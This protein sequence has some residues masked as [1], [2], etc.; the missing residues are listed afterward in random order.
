MRKIFFFLLLLFLFFGTI[1][2]VGA[3]KYSKAVESCELKY[4][5]TNVDS[6]CARGNKVVS[7]TAPAGSGVKTIKWGVCCLLN[8]LYKT[9][10]TMALVIMPI[11]LLVF[12]YAA[13]QFM[14]SGGDA[15]KLEEVKR[16]ILYALIGVIIIVL[17]KSILFTIKS[18]V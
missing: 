7:P 4:N 5:F 13:F 18:I 14:T 3:L 9:S 15:N 11:A 1:K 12:L 16:L 8:S 17:A 10:D 2:Q 6:N